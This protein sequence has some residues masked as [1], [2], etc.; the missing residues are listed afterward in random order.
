MALNTIQGFYDIETAAGIIPEATQA[1]YNRSL[2][3]RAEPLLVYDKF[4]QRH[5]LKTRSGKSMIFRRWEKL[6]DAT[7]PLSEGVTPAGSTLTR[8]ELVAMIKQYGDWVGLSDMLILTDFD[9]TINEASEVLGEQ[10]GETL[11]SIYRDLLVA[12]TQAYTSLTA[13]TWEAYAA[14][15]NAANVIHPDI[16]DKAINV[17]DRANA[18]KF[19]RMV[20]GTVKVNTY[21]I[22][23][24]YWGVV[25][26][27]VTKDFYNVSNFTRGTEFVPVE[28]YSAHT[29]TM[30]G[31]VGKYRSIRFVESTN[32][33]IWTDVGSGT[34]TGMRTTG[35]SNCDVYGTLIF[36]RDA[37]GIVPLEKGS[38][39]T[40]IHRAGSNTDPLNQRNTVG[41]KHA[42]TCK[43][44]NDEWMVRLE[45]TAS[46]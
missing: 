3:E 22:A 25:H 2:L 26:P 46:A 18:K 15:V 10:M 35:G 8:T 5:P 40:I 23:A 24:S 36:G 42:T 34:T 4:G 19:T 37:Y 43:I 17:L 16:L 27:D 41:W 33:K 21:P 12:G 39:R 45:T 7:T 32:A 30:P 20:S 1:T 11:D 44:L 6:D 29:Q 13:T 28:Q 31:E 9:P 14:K 38:A